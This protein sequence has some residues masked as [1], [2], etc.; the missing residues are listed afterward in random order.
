MLTNNSHKSQVDEEQER[1]EKK[2]EFDLAKFEIVR[3]FYQIL[4]RTSISILKF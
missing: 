1:V 2:L 4:G 3:D